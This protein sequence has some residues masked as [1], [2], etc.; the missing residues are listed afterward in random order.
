[1][2]D[3]LHLRDVRDDDRPTLLALNA[4]SVAVLSPMN[5]A[6]LDQL[7]AASAM[8]RVVE[9]NRDVRAFVL[10]FREGADY[11]SVNYRWFDARYPRFL[12]VDRVVVDTACRG[13]GF[14]Q[15]LYADVFERARRDD[16]PRVTC[17][18]D[19]EPPNPASER[20]HARQ[21]FVEVGRQTLPG[22][23]Q[24][25]LQAADVAQSLR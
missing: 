1:M 6:R 20:F 23:K 16:V 10:A 24:V 25:S 11:D 5:D 9:Q 7:L 17:E 3:E 22:G 2:A 15:R 19:V 12:Y 18:F 8:C 21:G 14:G 4:A 13:A